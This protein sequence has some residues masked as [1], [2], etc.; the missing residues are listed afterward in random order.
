MSS[1]SNEANEANQAY[2]LAILVT[3]LKSEIEQW[4][5]LVSIQRQMIDNQDR[6]IAVYESYI[7]EVEDI[8]KKLL[9]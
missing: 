6:L 2:Q 5:N 1:K 7:K 9:S 8:K 4:E 3:D